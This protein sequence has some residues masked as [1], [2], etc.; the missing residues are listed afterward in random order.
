LAAK[1]A[2]LHAGT[3]VPV[4]SDGKP[5]AVL[6]FF[7]RTTRRE[8]LHLLEL[9]RAATAPLGTLIQRKQAEDQLNDYRHRLE[10][11]VRERTR[12]LHESQT[13]LRMADR[14]ASIGTLAA[15]LGHDMNNMLLPVRARLNALRAERE[16]LSARTRRNGDATSKSVAYLQ[17][18]ADGPHF[19][20]M[21]PDSEDD[22]GETTNL[23]D[24]SAQTGPVLSKAVPK[25][26]K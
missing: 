19:L 20:A 2:G 11:M 15:G 7:V 18:L 1:E 3:A 22:T 10:E 25:H 4:L 5:I 9:V 23:A 24:W 14:L 21:D 12:E 26:V 8:D 6:L 17:Q 13:K 16:T